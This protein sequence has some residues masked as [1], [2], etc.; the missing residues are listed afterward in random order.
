MSCRLG[1]SGSTI[2]S[3]PAKLHE[4]LWDG[5][6][7][8][9]IGEFPDE[10]AFEQFLELKRTY[11]FTFGVHSPLYRNQSKYDL[12]QAV[13]FEPEQAWEQLEREIVLLKSLGALYVL[14]HFPYFREEMDGDPTPLICQGIERIGML[15]RK[16]GLPVV[17]EPKLGLNKNGA[18]IEYFQSSPIELWERER[19]GVCIDI[20]DLLIAAG[21]RAMEYAAKWKNVIQVVHLHNVEL[22]EEGKYWWIPVH[23]AHETDG[24]HFPIEAL[25]RQLAESNEALLIF[26]HTPHIPK[27]AQF[28]QEGY[29]WIKTLVSREP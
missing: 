13:H 22:Q 9:E 3:D 25:L 27:S 15:Q 24:E 7:H 6:D 28:V 16:H 2:L 10:A 17:C 20:G 18:G 29:E 4:L 14:V 1:V 12:L 26:E 11:G 8:I 21:D 19:L 23:P 5:I